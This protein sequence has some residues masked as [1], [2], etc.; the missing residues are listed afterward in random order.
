MKIIN[1]IFFFMIAI[2]FS[3]NLFA[4]RQRLSRADAAWLERHQEMKTVSDDG[5]PWMFENRLP[6]LAIG[7]LHGDLNALLQILSE[8][9][10]ID[11]ETGRWLGKAVNLVL[12]GDLVN[13]AGQ[14]R[15]VLEYL[16][17]LQTEMNQSRG[18][19][20]L[21]VGN[22]EVELSK[23]D[24]DKMPN[25]DQRDFRD[26]PIDGERYEQIEDIFK[27]RNRYSQFLSQFQMIVKV[28]GV[29]YVHAGLQGWLLVNQ[30]T[31]GSI[32]STWRAWQQYW[33]SHDDEVRRE[34]PDRETRWIFND[35][36]GPAHLQDFRMH[37]R[38]RQALERNQFNLL[39]QS[40]DAD[41]MVKGHNV[42]PNDRIHQG[43]PELGPAVISIDTGI[44]ESKG[45]RISSLY[46]DQRGGHQV[47]EEFYFER[48]SKM[49][50]RAIRDRIRAVITNRCEA[51]L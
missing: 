19:L 26:Y 51:V 48:P 2:S 23:G 38:G 47:M 1:Q 50:F 43:H 49:K 33:A 6:T 25:R 17:K 12:V 32:N 14:S 46:I 9:A 18:F 30:N 36:H 37:Q 4:Q 16:M 11:A 44:S 35:D 40:L 42:T 22:H 31:P 13:G 29:V 45:G 3:G 15:L 28:N 8:M 24:E 39:M 27:S 41:Y 21:L 10:L 20:H 5:R 34:R 7:D